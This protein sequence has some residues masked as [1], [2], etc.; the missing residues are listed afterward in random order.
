MQCSLN[1]CN[2]QAEYDSKN[3]FAGGLLF[4]V[5]VQASDFPQMFAD[6]VQINF[7]IACAAV[8]WVEWTKRR[9]QQFAI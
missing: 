8:M 6:A 3:N 1:Y 4:R 9:F 2:R 5:A 7:S